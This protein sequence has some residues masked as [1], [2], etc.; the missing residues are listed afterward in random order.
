MKK[1][2]LTGAII[3]L[4]SKLVIAQ[5]S[6]MYSQYTL[7]PF[8]INPA[9]AGSV[10]YTPIT[11]TARQQ[12]LGI[13][14][15]PSTQVI[16]G[17]TP[18][19][20]MNIGIGGYIFNDG[21]GSINNTGFQGSF[22]YHLRLDGIKSKLGIGVGFSAFEYKLDERNLELIDDYDPSITNS[23]YN[24]FAADANA[25]L[26]LYG[27]KYYIGA[28]A[29]QLLQF[30]IKLGNNDN[31]DNKLV[32]HYYLFGGYKFG[33]GNNFDL[34]P[35]VF[36]KSTERTPFQVDGN[37]KLYFKKDYWLGASYRSD[38][39]IVGLIGF[40]IKKIYFGYAFDYSFKKIQ[41]YSNGSH[42]IMIGINLGEKSGGG[43]SLL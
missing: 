4:I 34:E 11:L 29:N 3:F 40:K 9:I 38:E 13:K 14:D 12:W 18:I 7:N 33:L 27:D 17:Y 41:N 23:V 37:L 43:K 32:R 16:S 30:K 5:Q 22:A 25:G 31:P 19:K 28:S 21:F 36:V 2:L 20:S 1:I 6:P 26:Y 10:N 15:A 39:D 35:S 8:L 42:E 24:D